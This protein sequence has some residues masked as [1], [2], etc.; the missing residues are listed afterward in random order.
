[1]RQKSFKRHINTVQK[2]SDNDDVDDELPA[3]INLI[4]E[5]KYLPGMGVYDDENKPVDDACRPTVVEHTA[6]FVCDPASEFN[7]AN[8]HTNRFLTTTFS[9]QPI[10]SSPI[11][12]RIYRMAA[13]G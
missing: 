2:S 3:I 6:H 4:A 9:F 12:K 10:L 13:F 8:L 1:M 11:L 7:E 5:V